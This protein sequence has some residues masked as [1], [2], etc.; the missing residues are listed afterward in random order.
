MVWDFFTKSILKKNENQTYDIKNSKEISHCLKLIPTYVVALDLSQN[1]LSNRS[2]EELE[3]V[4]SG[5]PGHITS[6]FLNEN[7]LARMSVGSKKLFKSLPNTVKKLY[8][9]ENDLDLLSPEVCGDVLS[10]LPKTLESIILS[11]NCLYN[12]HNSSMI[13]IFNKLPSGIKS[14]DIS[15]NYFHEA[16]G[17]LLAFNFTNLPRNLV[18][19]NLSQ[20]R[21]GHK[22][23]LTHGITDLKN[24]L[25]SIAKNITYLDLSKND[26]HLLT[27]QEF[28]HIFETFS[29]AI[30][31]LNLSENNLGSKNSFDLATILAKVSRKLEYLDISTNELGRLDEHD[32]SH[33]LT[34]LS[35]SI[36]SLAL[37]DNNLGEKT[38]SSLKQ[39]LSTIPEA[40]ERLDL[41]S[42]G[43]IKGESLSKLSKGI[44][45]LDLS[46]NSFGVANDDTLISICS[47][48][49]E[50]LSTLILGDNKLNKLSSALLGKAISQ[51][52]SI[53]TLGLAENK[54]GS[55]DYE[56]LLKIFSAIPINVNALDLCNNGIHRLKVETLGSL[57]NSIPH[58]KC[59]YL[60]FHEVA[61]MSKKQRQAFKEIFST[62]Q[63]VILL[64]AAG[65]EVNPNSSLVIANYIRS[66]GGSSEIPSLKE[67]TSL[68]LK[69]NVD[70]ENIISSPLPDELK[71]F[72][73]NKIN[74]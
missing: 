60:S 8:L 30:S 53:E 37:R 38:A 58:L 14:L 6:L 29:V 13:E 26:I 56:P 16:P 74:F 57:V 9:S 28:E 52:V 45:T 63:K 31:G 34:S 41:S 10:S 62:I 71:E 17:D 69:N 55:L 35:T 22:K 4:F 7:G 27:A 43:L 3:E 47:N 24:L 70:T 59:V 33:I 54:L 1:K 67:L 65:Q 39:I 21:L 19:L 40:I 66:L 5:I 36:K 32:F 20:N 12:G 50:S 72:V 42:N 73:C 11:N 68:Y 48:L 2:V 15:N 23:D 44:K 64:D 18:S 46:A 49:P 61:S 51:L 25:H